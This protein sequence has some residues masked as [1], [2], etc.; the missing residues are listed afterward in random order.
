MQHFTGVPENQAAWYGKNVHSYFSHPQGLF[1][2][3]LFMYLVFILNE[4][5]A[6]MAV[7]QE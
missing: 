5:R 6:E 4:E 3:V 1:R 7:L 2:L